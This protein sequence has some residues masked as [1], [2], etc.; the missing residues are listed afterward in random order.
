MKSKWIITYSLIT[1]AILF[2]I[3]QLFET[4]YFVSL[5]TKLVLFLSLPFVINRWVLGNRIHFKMTAKNL[6]F[7]MVVS[8]SIIGVIIIAYFILQNVIDVTAIKS[9]ING[10]QKIDESMYLFPIFYTIFANSFIE[11][12][13]FRGFIFYGLREKPWMA[14][15]F[16][17]ALFAI[18]H[19][20]I[21][22]TWFTLP[23]LLLTLTGLF[24]G[25][26]I[27]AYFVQKTDSLF[28]SYLIHMAA[29][30]G[31]VI[32]GVFGMGLFT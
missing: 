1:V 32:V 6:K 28:G 21:V 4:G 27:F 2:V 18:Y 11:E 8:L 31:V 29:D 23:L 19:I 26:L 15:I 20:A 7:M 13:F 12:Y 16:S 14:A 5:A 9:D 24:I 22:A 10:R 25:G 17:S 3:S 30:I